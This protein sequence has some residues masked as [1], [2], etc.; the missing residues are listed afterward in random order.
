MIA[1]L[2]PAC[3]SLIVRGDRAEFARIPLTIKDLGAR[4]GAQAGVVAAGDHSAPVTHLGMR[5]VWTAVVLLAIVAIYLLMWRGWQSRG[6]RQSDVPPPPRVPTDLVDATE[7]AGAD[8]LPGLRHGPVEAVYVSTTTAGDWLDRIVVHG[9]GVRSNAE[10]SVTD[11]GVL[12]ER[13]G[14]PAL[15]IPAGQLRGAHTAT[16]MAGKFVGANGL[17][18]L[19][20]QLGP[21]LVDTGLRC[22]RQADREPLLAAL[23][24]LTTLTDST[25]ST[26]RSTGSSSS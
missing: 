11:S 22:E 23:A 7:E 26:G 3:F 4:L 15:W 9:L 19:E 5:L 24:A 2:A 13:E 20:W 14:A 10:V 8:G 6:R 1:A 12:I 17:V 25:D 16:G 18:V 21:R